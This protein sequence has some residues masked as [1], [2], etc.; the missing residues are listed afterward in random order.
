M[1]PQDG[2]WK[3]TITAD[4]TNV[5]VGDDFTVSAELTNTGTQ[6]QSTD[7]YGSWAIACSWATQS[8]TDPGPDSLPVGG[9]P[10]GAILRP[11]ESQTFSQTFHA[12]ADYVGLL[13]CGAGV[14][15]HGDSEAADTRTGVVVEIVAPP[16]T[17]TTFVTT[18]PTTTTTA[19]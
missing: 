14:V 19:P 15:F 1:Q 9:F 16:V 4:A 6:L 3:A 7:G 18:E 10:E 2:S 17:S 12:E 5:T 11:G 8:A 13:R